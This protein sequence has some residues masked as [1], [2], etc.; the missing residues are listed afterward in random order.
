MSQARRLRSSKKSIK[1]ELGIPREMF[2][3]SIIGLVGE[4]KGFDF[5]IKI[6]KSAIQIKNLIFVVIGK[7][8]G[9][10]G[11]NCVTFLKKQKNVK[12]LGELNNPDSI[13][14]ITDVVIR[15][16]N[17]LPLGRTVWEG[18]FAGGLALVPINKKDNISVIQE[19]IGKYIF[20]YKALDVDSCIETLKEIMKHYPDTVLESGFPISENIS[21]SAE[22]FFNVIQS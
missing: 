17:Y 20:T 11:E 19:Y 4:Q 10:K 5:F 22:Q 1:T 16:E 6:V 3:V 18:I 13:Y 2:V 14:A 9:K 21:S 15:C 8:Q 12:Y 7:P